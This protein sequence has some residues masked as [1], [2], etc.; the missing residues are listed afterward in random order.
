MSF[1]KTQKLYLAAP[2]FNAIEREFNELLTIRLAQ[3]FDVFLPQRD[4]GLMTNMIQEGVQPSD[5]ARSVFLRDI[6]ALNNSD[7]LLIVLDGR[8]VDE[9]AAF[10]LGYAYALQ[11]AC[12][13]LQTDTRRLLPTGNNPMIDEACEKIFS[14]IE[15]LIEW[16]GGEVLSEPLRNST[17]DFAR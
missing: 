12:Y 3:F 6:D 4:G 16:A 2:L 10:E 17:E 1:E 5:A 14:T 11:K 15:E 13:A 9:G 7:I 8:T